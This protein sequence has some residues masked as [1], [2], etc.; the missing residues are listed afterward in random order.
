MVCPILKLVHFKGIYLFKEV[1]IIGARY[2]P[3]KILWCLEMVNKI[4][5]EVSD[6]ICH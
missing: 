3:R 6:D 5:Y 1:P 2:F 4:S